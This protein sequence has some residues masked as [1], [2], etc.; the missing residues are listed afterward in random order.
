MLILLRQF[1]RL[2]LRKRSGRYFL[3]AFGE[4]VLIVV[5]I[6]I[7]VQIGDWKADRELE[8]Q[9]MELIEN[10]KADFRTTLERAEACIQISQPR[11]D[12]NSEN[13]QVLAGDLSAV[14]VEKLR[15]LSM[16]MVVDF[17]PVLGS[18]RSAESTGAMGLVQD[19]ILK[20]LFIE[21]ED[22]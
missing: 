3:Y 6:L 19:S 17:Q 12:T 8:R 13:L 4:I 11:L 10:L 18:Y 20:Q 5:G 2:E 1:R 16:R 14:N 22:Q 9:R 21:M 15:S 7:A